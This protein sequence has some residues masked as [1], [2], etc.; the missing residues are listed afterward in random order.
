MTTSTISVKNTQSVA[1]QL[2]KSFYQA[3]QQ[4]KL[5]TLQAEVDSLLQQLMNLERQRL[6]TTDQ[7]E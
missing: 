1:S 4:A 7:E 3:D 6:A 5:R 2:N